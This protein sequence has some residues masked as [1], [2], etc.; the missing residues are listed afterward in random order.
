MNKPSTDNPTAIPTAIDYIKKSHLFSDKKNVWIEPLL[1]QVLDN[2]FDD[3]ALEAVLL[4]LIRVEE[5]T[6]E[7]IDKTVEETTGIEAE[8]A[9]Q[10]QPAKPVVIKHIVSIE[11]ISNIGLLT[12]HEPISLRSGLN[13]FYGKNAAGKSSIYLGFC[14][15]FGK[16]KKVFANI[17][18]KND[19]SSCT[20][21]CLD[22]NDTEHTHSWSSQQENPDSNVM[23]FDS[24]IANTLIEKDQVNQFELAHLHMEYFSFLHNLFAK[25]EAFLMD[26][27]GKIGNKVGPIEESLA[28]DVPLIFAPD[29]KLTKGNVEAIIFS[30]EDTKALEGIEAEV[31]RIEQ[32]SSD[33]ITKNLRAA[34]KKI[35]EVLEILGTRKVEAD[36]DGKSV[37][38]WMLKYDKTFFGDYGKRLSKCADG[39]AKLMSS[40]K[41]AFASLLPNGWAGESKW[42]SFIE[43]SIEFIES[44][45]DADQKKY[46]DE[47]CVYCNQPLASDNAKKLVRAYKDLEEATRA[48]I[49][50][51]TEKL[52]A[53]ALILQKQ[54]AQLQNFADGKSL[55]EGEFQHISREGEIAVDHAAIGKLLE[56]LKECTEAQSL[57]A[58]SDFDIEQI[59]NFWDCYMDLHKEFSAQITKLTQESTDRTKL[60]AELQERAMPYRQ[61]KTVQDHRAKILKYVAY[62][63]ANARIEEKLTCVTGLRQK[64]STLET[65]F[66]TESVME[67]FKNCL[68]TEYKELNF[69]VPDV[70]KISPKT[71]GIEKKRVYSLGDKRLY[72]IFSEAERKLHSLADFFAQCAINKFTGVFVFDDPVSSL[73]EEYM[74]LVAKRIFKLVE[75]KNQVIVFTHNLVFLNLLIDTQK[76]SVHRVS[77]LSNQVIIEPDMRIGTEAQLKTKLKE[78][79]KRMKDFSGRSVQEISEFELR[80][81]YDLMSGYIEDYVEIVFFKNVI[82][83][84]RPNIR[85]GSLDQ[86]KGLQT[87]IIDVIM[88][89]YNQTSRKGSRHSQPVGAQPP[90][91]N[92]LVIHVQKLKTSLALL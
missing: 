4:P 8:A 23:I 37:I 84:Y 31:K 27:Q 51:E 60:L 42:Q 40:G 58:V 69:V 12:R 17:L 91:Y 57:L 34:M 2:E 88:E 48:A 86:L 41:A 74:E 79:E 20:I 30:E 26:Y 82:N 50:A 65:K 54:T 56:H 47:F 70:W 3:G 18:E 85:M 11:D 66:S 9:P 14:K 61:K 29:F 76:D 55:I 78:I 80:N 10:E 16:N 53:L 24:L 22:E 13:V 32:N 39:K 63:E 25:I 89:M 33:A 45:P 83:R 6:D 77:R 59:K 62:K 43:R 46:T 15:V 75:A 28:K 67:E 35:E 73:D 5:K 92:E 72:D 36:A 64:T 1:Q 44:L 49:K 21:K 38:T 81:V 68:T 90:K 87:D 19:Q 7:P 71:S 52:A